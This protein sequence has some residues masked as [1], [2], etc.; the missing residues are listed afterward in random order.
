[1]RKFHKNNPDFSLAS[2]QFYKLCEK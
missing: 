1:M 2:S